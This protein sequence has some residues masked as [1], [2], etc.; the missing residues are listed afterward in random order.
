MKI[1]NLEQN[2]PEW[3]KFRRSHIGASD[4]SVIMRT[5]PYKSIKKLWRDKVLGEKE[6]E[7]AAM[8]WGKDQEANAR[9]HFEIE[10]KCAVWPQVVIHPEHDW[11]SASLDGLDL[12][13]EFI[14]EIKCPGEKNHALAMSGVIPNHYIAQLQHQLACTGLDEAYYYSF[15]GYSGVSIRLKRDDEFIKKMI[16]EEYKFWESISIFT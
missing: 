7:N 4:A 8:N 5:N 2:T 15:D 9:I 11:M 12:G 10:H 1:I 13:Q 3:L 6:Y 16:D 14:V